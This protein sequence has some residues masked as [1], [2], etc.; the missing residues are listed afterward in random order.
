MNN[1]HTGEN[2][3]STACEY[4]EEMLRAYERGSWNI[5]VRRA[6]EVVELSLKGLLKMMGVEYP[7]SHDVGGVFRRICIEM[8]LKVNSEKLDELEQI[9]SDLAEDRAPAFYMERAYSKQEADKAKDDAGKV[10]NFARS[11]AKMLED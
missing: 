11:F 2:L 4:Y 1:F 6:Q 7:K 10:L 3:L 5:V 8:G 9:S